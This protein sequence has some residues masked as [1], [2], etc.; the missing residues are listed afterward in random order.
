MYFCG[1]FKVRHTS[2]GYVKCHL[3]VKSK[4]LSRLRREIAILQ[5]FYLLQPAYRLAK[6]LGVV[7]KVGTRVCQ[8]GREAVYHLTELEAAN[9]KAR[10]HWMKPIVGETR[11][12][13]RRKKCRIRDPGSDTVSTAKW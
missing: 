8:R 10:S 11:V 13:R 7:V 1:S 2:C 3:S 4:N 5:G 9:S 12:S 6:D